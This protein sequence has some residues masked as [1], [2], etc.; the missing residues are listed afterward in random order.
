MLSLDSVWSI[1]GPGLNGEILGR[2]LIPLPSIKELHLQCMRIAPKNGDNYSQILTNR[3]ALD[4]LSI[5]NVEL[6]GESPLSSLIHLFQSI[7]SVDSLHI[8]DVRL[9]DGY[10]NL[11]DTIAML[12]SLDL[13]T[14]IQPKSLTMSRLNIANFLFLRTFRELA[15]GTI[16]SLRIDVPDARFAIMVGEGCEYEE[17]ACEG[18]GCLSSYIKLSMESK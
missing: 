2:L 8:D 16:Q 1:E 7:S 5:K 13:P 10:K 17:M 14:H 18:M 11:H 3:K 6:V 15:P 12:S 9:K 4:V